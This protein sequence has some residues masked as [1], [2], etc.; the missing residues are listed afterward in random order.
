VWGWPFKADT[1]DIRESAAI[2]VI[3][4]LLEKGARVKAHDY[5]GMENMRQVFKDKVEWC[6][7]PGHR[8]RRRRRGRA[9][10]TDWPQYTTLPVP[11]DRRDDERA[12]S[13]S[14]AAT[15]CIAT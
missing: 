2:D 11:Q 13:S 12:R 4:Y 9:W 8:R 14:T 15:A 5:K 3:Q 6:R 1:D 10:L 7:D